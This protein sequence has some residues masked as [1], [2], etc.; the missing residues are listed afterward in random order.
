MRKYGKSK[1]DIVLA[2]RES[3]PHGRRCDLYNDKSINIAKST[4][5]KWWSDSPVT[6]KP[7]SASEQVRIWKRE[8]PE[9]SKKDCAKD[10]GVTERIVYMRWNDYKETEVNSI[11]IRTGDFG[12][13]EFVFDD[14]DN[15]SEEQFPK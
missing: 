6:D 14:P 4:V 10:L 12:Q 11:P 9:G 13:L 5:D 7:Y 8:H 15:D 1:R 3:H 2:W